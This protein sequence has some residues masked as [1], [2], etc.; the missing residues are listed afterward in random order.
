MTEEKFIEKN[1]ARWDRLAGF[2]NFKSAKNK[3]TKEELRTFSEL[4]RETSFHLAYARTHYAGSRTVAYLNQ[5]VGA[6]HNNFYVRRHTPARDVAG[7][8]TKS[9]P[10]AVRENK[11][12]LLAAF[13]TF[14]V[15]AALAAILVAMNP[16]NISWF[17]PSGLQLNDGSQTWDYPI[18]SAFIMSNN[19]LVAVK[20]FCFGITAGLG[21]LYTLLMNG[22]TVGALAVYANGSAVGGGSALSFWSLLMPHGFI[23]LTA[24]FISGAG[25]LIIGKHLLIPGEYTRGH[26][27]IIGARKA[28]FLLPGVAA[29]LVVAG[30]IEGFFTPLPINPLLKISFAIITAVGLLIYFA[31]SGSRRRS[32]NSPRRSRRMVYPEPSARA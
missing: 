16:D 18:I 3:M 10:A 2:S 31:G 15:G 12:Y 20:A 5:L 17:F 9:F 27:L 29:M 19:I 21:T 13:L 4:F 7:Y 28:A 25:G 6:M 1:S 24:I 30:L 8:F 26:S 22:L 11:F 23:E 14:A 32:Q